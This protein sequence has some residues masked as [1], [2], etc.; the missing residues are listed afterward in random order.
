MNLTKLL[1]WKKGL[2]EA[3][4]LLQIPLG[5]EQVL[6]A[7]QFLKGSARDWW[8]SVI[9]QS[10]GHELQHF[11]NIY[12]ALH[13]RFIPRQIAGIRM[14]AW[15]SLYH[16]G[17]VHEYMTIVNDLALAHPL[18]DEA[19]F[20]HAWQGLRPEYKAEV[21]HLLHQQGRQTCSLKELKQILLSIEL[22]YPYR[23]PKRFPPRFQSRQVTTNQQDQLTPS[24]RQQQQQTPNQSRTLF[25]C[26]ICASPQHH[27]EKCPKKKKSGCPICGSKAHKPYTCP[28]QYRGSPQLPGQPPSSST[29][30]RVTTANINDDQNIM[31]CTLATKY[32]HPHSN[33][34]RSLLYKLTIQGGTINVFVD[35]GSELSLISE[36]VIRERG[37][38]CTPLLCP[39][40]IVFADKSRVKAHA[41][42]TNL[43]IKRRNWSDEVTCVVIPSLTEPIYLG[44]DWLKRWN[45]II[46]WISGE[47]QLPGSLEAWTPLEK[48]R[49]S[50]DKSDNCDFENMLTLSASR[51][52]LRVAK[53]NE[54]IAQTYGFMIVR[55]VNQNDTTQIPSTHP[56]VQDLQVSF[57]S[58]FA[59][60]TGIEQN[61]PVRHQIRIK[62][63][64]MPA[65]VKP[66]RFTETQKGELKTQIVELL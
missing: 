57:A 6:A 30:A 11:D 61:P 21:D 15:N 20:W 33:Q 54:Q 45:P 18:G 48:D 50:Y 25:A 17:T 5:R 66:F 39:V 16:R 52:C 62:P 10:L 49:N 13:E 1:S 44:R 14:K 59:E 56:F 58:V 27:M 36:R 60:A 24:F 7:V 32:T 42:V 65:H 12:N 37:I 47:I 31:I 38:N 26:W 3:F 9:G 51:K 35:P 29:T 34:P 4:T 63:D 2:Q 41:Q 19:A 46:D 64:A 43:K 53:R 28:Q 40:Y 22:K 8:E 23:E 55:A